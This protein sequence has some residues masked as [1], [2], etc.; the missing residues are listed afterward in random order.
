MLDHV[1]LTVSDFAKSKKFFV[2]SLAALG[3]TVMM[4]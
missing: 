2:K 1:G 4:D 3:Y